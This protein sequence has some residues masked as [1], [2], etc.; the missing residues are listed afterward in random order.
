MAKT[1]PQVLTE[2]RTLL[3]DESLPY[4][5]DDVELNTKIDNS[6]LNISLM[7]QCVEDSDDV[8][9]AADTLL[10]ALPT[11]GLKAMA[12]LHKSKALKKI[13]PRQLGQVLPQSDQAP[14]FWFPFAKK[15]GVYPVP[16]TVFTL[17]VLFSKLTAD[18]TEL[19][20]EYQPLS[21]IHSAAWALIKDKKYASARELYNIYL[22][23]LGFMRGDLVERTSD[24]K[25]MLEFADA[26]TR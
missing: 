21:V 26:T 22:G 15:F 16:K 3:N 23:I 9:T 20:D 17:T 4:F 12:V 6:A 14:E 19:G 7:A 10:Y 18:V 8:N 2:I 5:W 24:S 25:D 11:G 1:K 13:H